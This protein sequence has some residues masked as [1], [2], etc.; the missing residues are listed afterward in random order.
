M[1]NRHISI[2][3]RYFSWSLSNPLAETHADRYVLGKKRIAAVYGL[4]CDQPKGRH[5]ALSHKRPCD[6]CSCYL[7]T[8]LFKGIKKRPGGREEKA[9]SGSD[10]DE[11]SAL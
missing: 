7:C 6:E 8:G 1:D 4:R 9:I 11:Y 2:I 3:D 5:G 10:K